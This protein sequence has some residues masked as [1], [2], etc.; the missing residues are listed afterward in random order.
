MYDN[1]MKFGDPNGSQTAKAMGLA[2]PSWMFDEEWRPMLF[3][4]GFVGTAAFFLFLY[5]VQNDV[6]YNCSNGISINSKLEMKQ[7]IVSILQD[8]DAQQRSKGLNN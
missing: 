2:I 3:A 5:Q 6:R 8:N 1:W 4:M 7:M